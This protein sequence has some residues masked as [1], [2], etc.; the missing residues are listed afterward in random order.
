MKRIQEKEENDEIDIVN[1][2]REIPKKMTS[3][4]PR[5][6]AIYIIYQSKAFCRQRIPKSTCARKETVYIDILI[7]F[8]NGDR[9]IM[10]RVRITSGPAT[11]MRKWNQFSHCR[12]TSTKVIP[13]EKLKLATFRRLVKT[14]KEA[15]SKVP[16][17]L[18]GCSLALRD[19]V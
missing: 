4:N 9:I 1:L 3:L 8:R 17:A 16:I 7:A 12:W 5:L 14:S 11:R 18:L 6:K 15:A 10:Q 2:F 19:D 13:K